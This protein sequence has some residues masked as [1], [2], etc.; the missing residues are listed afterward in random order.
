VV[1]NAGFKRFLRVQKVAV[2]IDRDAVAADARLD[3]K[4]VLLTNTELEPDEVAR[5]YKSLW[6]V[7]RAFRETKHTLEVRPLYHHRHDTTVGHIVACFLAS[8]LKVDLQRRRPR[9]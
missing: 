3:G 9:G 4:F 6:R 8:R 5:A 7:E 2:S 1:G